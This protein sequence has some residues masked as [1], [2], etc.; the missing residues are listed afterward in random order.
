M[1]LRK[2]KPLFADKLAALDIQAAR[3]GRERVTTAIIP[4][5]E[6][7]GPRCH[8]A[9]HGDR[10]FL[11]M[12]SNSYLGLSQHPAVIG[13]AE[14]A[15]RRFGAGPGAVRFISGTCLAHTELEEKL[16]RFHGR[17]AAMIMSSAYATVMG[18]LPQ[19]ITEETL[20]VSDALNHNCIIN[21]IRL[22]QPRAKAV[23]RHLD[24]ED[25][26][27][28]LS[29]FR[30]RAKRVVVVTDGVF[31]MRGDHAPL[32]EL[33]ALCLGLEDDFPEGIITVAD[34]SHGVGAFGP[35]GRGSEEHTNSRVDILI[36]TLGKGFGINGG[37]VVG[38]SLFIDY[39]R[40]TAP[41]YIYSNPITPAE[42]AAASKALD[43]VDSSAGVLLLEKLQSSRKLFTHGLESLGYESIAGDHPIVPLII[44]D[45]AK[46]ARL[47]THLFAH[48]ILAT[49]LNYPVVPKGDEEIRFQLN[50]G[51]TEKDIEF[52]LGAL[53]SFT[54]KR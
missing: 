47:V 30:G 25:L 18:V 31:S 43:I 11:R 39:L 2:I 53:K 42:A 5:K 29:D 10:K 6:G 36:G 9:G 23:Y 21:A 34:D 41:F 32:A 4:A 51:H 17:E 13:A 38:D 48:D 27:A 16:A 14:E 15:A 3:K 20:V 54:G 24:M 1:S 12:N 7:F 44:R 52:L 46:T 45:T 50:A 49:G 22:A 8:L 37:Y 40:E 35:S 28:R 26:T 33:T 19:L